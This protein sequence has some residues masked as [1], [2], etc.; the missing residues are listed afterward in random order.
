M[1][2]EGNGRVVDVVARVVVVGG[3]VDVGAGAA[4]GGAAVVGVGRAGGGAVVVVVARNVVV[5]VRFV[6]GG[7]C[8]VASVL[9]VAEMFRFATAASPVPVQR[10]KVGDAVDTL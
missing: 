3:N 8:P 2:V 10:A 7:F 5:V 6:A 4:V 1:L 9:V